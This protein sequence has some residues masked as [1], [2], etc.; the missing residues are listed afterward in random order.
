MNDITNLSAAVASTASARP[1]AALE[2]PLAAET[3]QTP[4]LAGK[5]L[6]VSNALS[7]IEKLVA[8]IETESADAR[9]SV[10]KMRINAVLTL[11]EGMNVN[12]TA[13]Q[14]EAFA[15]ILELGEQSNVLEGEL[16]ELYTKYG[17]TD[18]TL[19]SVIMDAKIK[20]LERAVERA[21]QE[22]KDHLENVEKAKELRESDQESEKVTELKAQLETAKADKARIA[23]LE[24]KISSISAQIDEATAAIGEKAL[25]NIA[26]ALEAKANTDDVTFD[27]KPKSAAELEKDALKEVETNPLKAIRE[28][29]ERQD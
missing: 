7:D 28:A 11:L 27:E 23:D 20:S 16:T 15:Q 4:I 29:L 5:S 18:T 6:T 13:E 24:S 10:A 3:A 14:S 2:Q 9:E 21:V 25:A 26:A 22:G 17:I 8:K 19:S 12:L 1:L